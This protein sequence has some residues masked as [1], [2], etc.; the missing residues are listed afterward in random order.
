MRF[1][2]NRLL[3]S[4]FAGPDAAP[5][6]DPADVSDDALLTVP[7]TL[8]NSDT[9]PG[10]LTFALEGGVGDL[11]EVQVWV[12]REEEDAGRGA[13][14]SDPLNQDQKAARQFYNCSPQTAVQV[15]T[16]DLV[17]FPASESDVMP[18]PGVVYIQVVS[19][20][21][22]QDSRLRVSADAVAVAPTGVVP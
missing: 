8:R 20:T 11:V 7:F 21:L 16:G 22:T 9:I 6:T 17:Q 12:L 15:V 19:A 2:M 14:F 4:S 1:L 3:P 10:R 13:A 5:R 18:P